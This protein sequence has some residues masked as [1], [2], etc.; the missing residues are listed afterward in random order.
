MEIIFNSIIIIG[1]FIVFT[2]YALAGMVFSVFD[3]ICLDNIGVKNYIKEIT[4]IKFI[5]L[6]L[7]CPLW[8]MCIIIFLTLS[9]ALKI[10]VRLI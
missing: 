7:F 10:I 6:L 9:I 8:C 4:L 5:K 2:I 3:V 1:F